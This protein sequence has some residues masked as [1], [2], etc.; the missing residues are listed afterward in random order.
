MVIVP[1]RAV[2]VFSAIEKRTSPGPVPLAV[3]VIDTH[4]ALLVAVH[5]HCAVVETATSGPAP[6]VAGAANV[7]GAIAT[8]HAAL[9][10]AACVTVNVCPA[11][12]NVPVRCPPAFAATV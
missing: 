4:G 12:V 3:D 7:A 5:G 10:T 9:W 6:P 8:T 1:T 2:D 11:T